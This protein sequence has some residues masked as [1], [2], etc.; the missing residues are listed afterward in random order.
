M[1][2]T[3]GKLSALPQSTHKKVNGQLATA[4]TTAAKKVLSKPVVIRP[5]VIR[6]SAAAIDDPVRLY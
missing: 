6:K 4:G 1:R 5:V 3:A 2:Y